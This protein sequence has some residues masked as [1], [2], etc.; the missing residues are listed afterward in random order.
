MVLLGL[1]RYRCIRLSGPKQ[2]TADR[3]PGGTSVIFLNLIG[4]TPARRVVPSPGLRR[5]FTELNQLAKL[6]YR[7]FDD[8][9]REKTETERFRLNCWDRM[10]AQLTHRQPKRFPRGLKL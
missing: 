1:K 3:K 10:S 2:P 5:L 8:S 4:Q 6:A 9:V 7:Q